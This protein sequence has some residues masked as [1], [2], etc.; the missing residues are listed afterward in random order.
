[1]GT[2]HSTRSWP[3]RYLCMDRTACASKQCSMKEIELSQ[4]YV[5]LVDDHRYEELRQW[6]WYA[7]VIGD[8]PMAVRKPPRRRGMK[9]IT[10]YMHRQI[11]KAPR[12]QIVHHRDH[13]TLNNQDGNLVVCTHTQHGAL[14]RKQDGCSSQFKGVTWSKYAKKWRAY[15][16]I[17]YR[18]KHLGYFVEE[19]DAALAY[20]LAA[21]EHFKE[22]ALLNDVPSTLRAV[23][24]D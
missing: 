5:A 16:V 10:T 15:I 17:D 14:Q 9:D 11:T 1:L 6:R 24:C 2:E 21:I 23:P 4:G 18:Q 7:L 22:F 19:E 12:G 3:I 13:D 8:R 20:N